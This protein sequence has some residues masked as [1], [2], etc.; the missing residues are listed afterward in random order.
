MPQF[1]F[2]TYSS[3]IFWLLICFGIF[4]SYIKFFFLPKLDTILIKR[5][6]EIKKTKDEIENNQRNA[7]M[8]FAQA[9]ENIVQSNLIATKII[10]E[11]ESKAKSDEELAIKEVELLQKQTIDE[12][13]KN[14]G[15]LTGET[16]NTAVVEVAEIVLKKIGMNVDRNELESIAKK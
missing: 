16:L 9:N 4:F 7:K 3:Q 15:S 1:N 6:D 5:N 11:A 10:E 12:I 14:Q 13:L 8:N 2:A